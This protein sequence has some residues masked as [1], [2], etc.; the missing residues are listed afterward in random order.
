MVIS[1]LSGRDKQVAL[2]LQQKVTASQMLKVIGELRKDE[3][4]T[5]HRGTWCW[6]ERL[7]CTCAYEMLAITTMIAKPVTVTA[8]QCF[9]D[10]ACQLMYS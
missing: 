3:H 9:K 8:V 4:W 6:V 5:A 1:V 10:P 2:S 7:A